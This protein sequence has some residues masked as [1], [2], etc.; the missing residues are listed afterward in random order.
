MMNYRAMMA[1]AAV[2][3]LAGSCGK[4]APA[5][6]HETRSNEATAVMEPVQPAVSHLGFATRVPKDADLFIAGFHADEMIGGM[7]EWLVQ[8][9][10]SK[11]EIESGDGGIDEKEIGKAMSY[12]GD[13]MF[14]FVGP[15]AGGKLQMLGES[16]RNISAAWIGVAAGAMLDAMGKKDSE[17]DL[18]KLGEGLSDDLIEKWMDAFEKDSRLQLPSLVMGWKPHPGKDSECCDALAKGLEELLVSKEGVAPVN[19]VAGGVA[20]AGYEITGREAF[21]EAVAGAREE[22]AKK[23][24]ND[25]LLKHISPAR[26]ERLLTALEEVRFTLAAGMVDGHVLLYLGNGAEGFRLANSPEDSLAATMD[27]KWT[28]QFADKRIAGA[29]YLSE[30][31]VRAALPWLDSSGYWE[32]LSRA[33]RPPVHDERIFRQLLA[34]LVET[35]RALARREASAWSAVCLNDDGWRIETRGGWPDP[36]LDFETPLRMTD[37]AISQN[38]AIRAH[39]VQQRGRNDLAW[40]RLEYFGTLLDAVYGELKSSGNPATAMLPEGALPRVMEEVRGINRAYREEFRA[41]IGDEVALVADFQGEVPP[42]PGI[43][44]ETVKNAKAPRFIIARPVKNRAMLDA[45]GKSYARS[46]RSLTAFASEKSD[47]NLPLILPQ[48][49]ES[50][51]LVTWYPPLPFIGGDFMPGVTMNDDLWMIGTSRSL[52]GGFAKSMSMASPGG[53]TGMIVEIE[54]API[55]VWFEDIYRRNETEAA[56]LTGDAPEEMQELATQENLE[57]LSAEVR[58]LQGLRYHKWMADGKQRTS[59]HVRLNPAK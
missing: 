6:T 8:F 47:T 32:A 43:S 25:E 54:F 13:E 37:A 14:L 50:G 46:W 22:L 4:K 38:P 12:V 29:A 45:A 19:F 15:G 58:R 51:G 5:N 57:R 31:M 20:L 24:V 3:A 55:R 44:A 10:V 21:G 23:S 33:I 11:Q 36:S 28:R 42:V 27:L 59:L 16:Y 2:L 35:D 17:P 26:I 41:G 1:G 48:S 40:K 18:S 56:G 9:G 30:P 49:I 34:G 53:E 39:W 7:V 52:V